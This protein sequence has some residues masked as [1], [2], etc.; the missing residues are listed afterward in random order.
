VAAPFS[1]LV[2]SAKLAGVESKAYLRLATRAALRGE[3]PPLPHE[4]AKAA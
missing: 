3:R 4:V 1:T 2:D